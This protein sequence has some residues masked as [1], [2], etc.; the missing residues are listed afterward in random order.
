MEPRLARR[1]RWTMGQRGSDFL[2][3]F[4]FLVGFLLVLGMVMD[5]QAGMWVRG[6]A[7]G[8]C[9]LALFGA[10]QMARRRFFPGQMPERWGAEEPRLRRLRSVQ[11]VVI[12]GGSAVFLVYGIGYFLAP[13]HF[14][15]AVDR[16]VLLGYFVVIAVLSDFLRDRE[17]VRRER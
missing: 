5:R 6:I 3:L 16:L 13:H 8:L 11:G 2:S 10:W 17:P 15:R 1:R 14:S 7:A 4:L 9:G 12:L